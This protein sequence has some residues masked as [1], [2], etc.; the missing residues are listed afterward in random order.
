MQIELPRA[1][2]VS[3][4]FPA[5]RLTNPILARLSFE[6]PQPQEALHRFGLALS[7]QGQTEPALGILKAALALAPEEADLWNDLASAF[8][9]AGQYAEAGAAQR[10]SLACDPA[11][12]Q[13]WLLLA[14]IDS[15]LGDAAAAEVGYLAALKLDPYLSEAAFGLGILCFGRRQF[16][17]AVK[18]L[19]Q[20]IASGGHHMGLYVCLGQALF[21]LGDFAAA[22]SALESAARFPSCDATVV[23]KLAQL[24]LI[25][26]CVRADAAAAVEAYG[27]IAGPH[28]SDIDRVTATAFHFLSGFGY[29]AAAIRLGEWRLGRNPQDAVQRYLLAAL[30]NEAIARAPDDYLVA[31]FDGFAE[32]FEAKLVDALGYRVPEKL[33][34]LLAK[35]GRRFANG[36]DL[37]CGT[38]LSSPLL[39]PMVRRLTG[40]DLSR[41]MLEKADAR[42][43]YDDLV[44]AEAGDFLD[45]ADEKFD[46][47]VAADVVIYFGDLAPLFARIARVMEPGGLFA[48]NAE[49]VEAGYRVL[50]SG[51]FAQALDYI[52]AVAAPYFTTVELQMTTIRLEAAQPV[53]GALVVLQRR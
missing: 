34:A 9:R 7:A 25:E 15:A 36:L 29:R 4:A 39:R 22:V 12:P 37:G 35:T 1:A 20:S 19:R 33:H 38:G 3:Q 32:T 5:W 46:L 43:L 27:Q 40:V 14:S 23:E 21:L 42:R 11:Q 44:E 10:R 13:G 47:V 16:T 18:W 50:P 51:R 30:R 8:Y 41:R 52:E 48:F 45:Q 28:A 53:E 24:K 17:E 26:T 6:Y 2:E 49:T 31:Y